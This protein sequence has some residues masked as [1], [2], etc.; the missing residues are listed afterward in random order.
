M[1]IQLVNN[2]QQDWRAVPQH[3]GAFLHCCAAAFALL[4]SGLY[5]FA[6]TVDH[7][8][9]NHFETRRR[10]IAILWVHVCF[11]YMNFCYGL[12]VRGARQTAS[13]KQRMQ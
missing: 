2:C 5:Y 9:R 8:Y 3:G 4:Y 7:V 6:F 12:D 1:L 13:E 11:K 10:E